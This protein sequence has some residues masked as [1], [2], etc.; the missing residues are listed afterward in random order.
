MRPC[1]IGI[2]GGIASGKSTVSEFL[3]HEGYT[4]ISS[5]HIG[6]EVLGY[7][8]IKNKLIGE[9][10]SGIIRN[11][12]ID[13][14]ILR[15]LVFENKTLLQKLNEIVHPEILKLMDEMVEHSSHE[16]LFFEVPLLFEAGMQNC[17][18]FIILISVSEEI[19]IDRLI[20][21]SQISEEEASNIIKAQMSEEEKKPKAGLIITNNG[22]EEGLKNQIWNFIRLIYQV[23]KRE[24]LTFTD[25]LK[26]QEK[27]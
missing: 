14:S 11:R 19:Q 6:H 7:P 15:K 25:I 1:I 27:E 21:R 8:E 16:Y 2:T 10:G 22:T 13:R 23:K 18:D 20:K 5:D 9:F 26:I 4:V 3:K 24:L 17:F 12:E